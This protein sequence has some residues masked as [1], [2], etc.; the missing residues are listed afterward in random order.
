MIKKERGGEKGPVAEEKPVIDFAYAS[1]VSISKIKK[2][3]KFNSEN[4]WVKRPGTGPIFAEEYDSVIGKKAS[5]DIDVDSHNPVFL[6]LRV[7]LGTFFSM[8]ILGIYLY[9]NVSR[10]IWYSL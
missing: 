7:R 5:K 4:V 2:G 1:V 6:F 10:S 9:S 3:E 8:H